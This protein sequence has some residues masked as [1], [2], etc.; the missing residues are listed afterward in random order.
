M[1]YPYSTL[2]KRPQNIHQVLGSN[3][4]KKKE[5][6]SLKNNDSCSSFL[7]KKIG[8][9]VG[10]LILF[11]L[12]FLNP[13]ISPAQWTN[14]MDASFLIGQPDFNTAVPGVT[15][16][17]LSSANGIAIDLAHNKMYVL[18]SKNHRVLRF[19][20]PIIS[21]YPT[22]EIVIGQPYFNSNLLGCTQNLLS[23]SP[24]CIAVDPE[25]NLW[26]SDMFNNRVIRFP[27]IWKVNYNQPN[28]DIVIGQPDFYSNSDGT[29]LNQL[30]W[31]QMPQFDANGNLYIA[32][33][34]NNRVLRFNKDN[35]KTGA[36]ANVYYGD[37]GS[38]VTAATLWGVCGITF[39]GSSMY[40]SDRNHHRVLR[41]DH[42]DSKVSASSADCVFGQPNFT[43]AMASIS[44]TGLNNPGEITSDA[45][46]TLFVDDQVNKRI[47]VFNNA[48]SLSNGANA[49]VVI[50]QTDFVS[51]STGCSINKFEGTFGLG[52]DKTNDILFVADGDNY[53]VLIF[54]SKKQLYPPLQQAYN[55]EF[56][57]TTESSTTISWTNGNGSK[58]LVFVKEGS[59]NLSGVTDATTYL[60]NSDFSSKGSQAGTSG[61]YCVY[62]GEA[63]SVDLKGLKANT[64]YTV[65]VLEY[66][67]EAGSEKYL[68]TTAQNN[69]ATLTTLVPLL[70]E[71]QATDIQFVNL[72]LHAMGIS[73]TKGSGSKRVVF[74]KEGTGDLAEVSNHSL[75]TASSDFS[76]RGTPAGNS[77]YYC[78]YNGDG[79]AVQV[80]NLK[81]NTLYTVRVCEYNGTEGAEEYLTVTASGNPAEH[82]I[83]K[84]DQVITFDPL[85]QKTVGDADFMLQATGGSSGNPVV[86]TCKDPNL[87]CGGNNG[88]TIT[89]KKA[90]TYTIYANQAGNDDYN[91]AKQVAQVL[92]VNKP[93]QAINFSTLPIKTYGDGSMVL[94]ATGGASGKPVVFTS[95]DPSIAECTGPNGSILIIK[96]PGQCKITANQDGDDW[97]SAAVPVQQPFTVKKA[98]QTITFA[99][100]DDKMY[101]DAP[102]RVSAT[103]GASGNPVYF[104]SSD[105]SIATCTGTNGETVSIVGGGSCIIY[106]HQ[107]GNEYYEP[108]ESIGQSLTVYKASQSILFD[109][110]STRTCGTESFEISASGGPSG[111]PVKFTS[112]DPSIA[113]CSGANG[114]IITI[115]KAGDCTIYADQVGNK[116]YDDAPQVA[117]ELHIIK[118]DQQIVF[119]PIPVKIFGD[120]PFVLSA[121]G[122]ASLN[123]ISF[124]M[125]EQ[126]IAKCSGSTVTIKN[127][128]S[129]QITAKQNGNSCYNPATASQTLTVK[130]A[131]QVIQF[132]AVDGEHLVNQPF[133]VSATGGGSN[134]P[135]VFT[136][137][138]PT[139]AIC[140]GTNGSTI[141]FLKA[142][143]CTIYANQAGS[144][145][146]EDAAQARQYISSGKQPQTIIFNALSSKTYGDAPFVISAIGGA[147]GNPVVFTS[148]DPTVAKCETIA[149]IT[150][151]TILRVGECT[152][153]A[154]QEG[155][156]AYDPAKEVSRLL[157][158]KKPGQVISFNA[159]RPKTFGDAPFTLSATGGASGNPVVFTSSHPE[160]VSCTGP[161]GSVVTIL[162]AGVCTIYANQAGNENYSAA[163][164]VGQ[165]LTIYKAN[166]IITF[167]PI[168]AKAYG[169][170]D[171]S[172]SAIGGASGLPIV[173]SSSDPS[174]A[175]CNGSVVTIHKAGTVTIYANQDGNESYYPANRVGQTI[176]ISPFLA[177]G[178]LCMGEKANFG[179]YLEGSNTYQWQE[180]QG[181]GWID[182]AETEVYAGVKTNLLS[183]STSINIKSGWKYRCLVNGAPKG[184]EGSISY[185]INTHITELPFKM[186]NY[187]EKDKSGSI[188]FSVSAQAEGTLLAVWKKN[189]VVLKAGGN[190]NIVNTV[191]G[192]N[193]LSSTLS[194]SNI[195]ASD[196]ADYV[197]VMKG[198]CGEAESNPIRLSTYG[199]PSSAEICP[200]TDAH[201]QMSVDNAPKGMSYQ[202]EQFISSSN[203]WI[204]L[205]DG[206]K[207]AEVAG[208]QTAV[209]NVKMGT[210]ASKQFRCSLTDAEQG[211]NIQSNAAILSRIVLSKQPEL[212]DF[213]SVQ[214][215][216]AS[217]SIS[218]NGSK[219][220][221]TWMRENGEAF[222]D[223]AYLPGSNIL[224]SGSK[225]SK[226]DIQQVGNSLCGLKLL[227]A[228]GCEQGSFVS[229][230]GGIGPCSTSSKWVLCVNKDHQL[231]SEFAGTHYQWQYKTANSD[232]ANL[233]ED[234]TFSH[235]Q[236]SILMIKQT[237]MALN[238]YWLRDV[239]DGVAKEENQITVLP[240]VSI[241]QQAEALQS[242]VSGET[243]SFSIT[244]TGA[245]QWEWMKDGVL[246]QDGQQA[247]GSR[248]SGAHTHQ[249]VIAGL[250]E[251][252]QAVY[253]CRVS[254]ACDEL[255]SSDAAL[256]VHSKAVVDVQP[257]NAQVC[258]G[259]VATFSLKASGDGR[260][261]YLWK[262][263]K[264]GQ[265]LDLD[266]SSKFAGETTSVLSITTSSSLLGSQYKCVV[267][268]RFGSSASNA[269]SF[270]FK[271]ETE[272]ISQPAAAVRATGASVSF[273]GLATGEGD[274]RYQWT[275]A[276]QAIAGAQSSTYTIPSLTKTDAGEYV[277]M[278]TA[279]CGSTSSSAAL[280]QVGDAPSFV[281]QPVD[282]TACSGTE[283]QFSLL[284]TGDPVLRYQW[285]Q[286]VEGVWISIAEDGTFSGCSSNVL[287]IQTKE[288]MD[289][290]KFRCQLLSP[291]GSALSQEVSLRLNDLRLLVSPSSQSVREGQ[292]VSWTMEASGQSPIAYQWR[293]N[294]TEM[295]GETQSVYRITRV[296]K[297]DEGDYDCVL[298][299]ACGTK[300]SSLAKLR[301]GRLPLVLEQPSALNVCSGSPV[302]WKV[303]ADVNS[304]ETIP[305]SS[306]ETINYQWQVRSN[307]SEEFKDIL[308]DLV[309]SGALS[310]R[311]DFV[312][313]MDL[314]GKQFRC[315]VSNDFGT[316]QSDVSSLKIGL[317]ARILAQPLA[318]RICS[319]GS[320]DFSTNASGT[321]E[322]SYQWQVESQGQWT[323]LAAGGSGFS[324]SKMTIH[325]N[326]GMDGWKFRCL[327]ADGACTT[328]TEAAL[329]NVQHLLELKKAPVDVEKQLGESNTFEV[330]ISGSDLKF[331]WYKGSA[332]SPK[333]Q[334]ITGA[335]GSS[336]HLS[337]LKA[338]DEAYYSVLV[339]GACGTNLY[340]AELKMLLVPQIITQPQ[341]RKV[342][343]GDQVGF[344]VR[345]LEHHLPNT[346]RWQAS[347]DHG[348]SWKEVSEQLVETFGNYSVL[349]FRASEQMSDL[350]F[351]CL[352]SNA[353]GTSISEQAQMSI[354]ENVKITQAAENL[355][356]PLH[357]TAV[358]SIRASGENLSYQ[359][360]KGTAVLMDGA[361][362]SGARTARLSLSDLNAA[363]E[364]AYS[365]QVFGDCSSVM[366]NAATL[367]LG[368]MP[369]SITFNALPESLL[370]DAD[371]KLQASTTSGLPLSYQSDNP[372][373]AVVWGD[374]V[375]L[376][377]IGTAKITATQS[378]NELYLPASPVT[379]ALVVKAGLPSVETNFANLL[380][381]SA[382]Q[383][384]ARVTSDGGLV[385]TERGICWGT[386]P[387]LSL[388]DSKIQEGT[389]LGQFSKEITGLKS[390]TQYYVKAYALNSLGLAYGKELS[391]TT[392]AELPQ[393]QASHLLFSK[394]DLTS[395]DLS[396]TRGNGEQCIVFIKQTNEGSASPMDFEQYIA[397]P[398][399]AAG[400]SIGSTGWYCVYKGSGT[401]ISISGL[402]QGKTYTAMVCEW[403][404]KAGQE[405]YLRVKAEGN[406]ASMI[407]TKREPLVYTFFSPDEDGRN[408]VWQID[409]ADLLNHCEITVYSRSNQVVYSS[410]GYPFP[411]DGKQN[412]HRLPMG[413]YY[414]VVK[415]E[416]NIKG[417]LVLM[418]R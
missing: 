377:G 187:V 198:D 81:R 224:F 53:R 359:W 94:T 2:I 30:S 394:V 405:R 139:V 119:D 292:S 164:Q 102:F 215:K 357:E 366:S 303:K 314:N 320:L 278:A 271:K 274:I 311:L 153:S 87:V 21:N 114:Q 287:R 200:G 276:G 146:Y 407:T 403:N 361:R 310:N 242:K 43:Q 355:Q 307:A 329:L 365:C 148:S 191:S 248:V 39:I 157:S 293:K 418:G 69:P 288:T 322:L 165:A 265:L 113:A 305:L 98:K 127:V 97:Y 284:A 104:T 351:R 128:G 207:D 398:E 378:G 28:A 60:A 13:K 356:K 343:L 196:A 4:T 17:T 50:G 129:T 220:R 160:I 46:G 66:T 120:A 64:S 374:K 59:G 144:D 413:E 316:V 55:I 241:S 136:S 221:Y 283:A 40:L 338:D 404:G 133:T 325:A 255:L 8:K 279:A 277:L 73:W 93:G 225:T 262:Q 399:F 395:F 92:V 286:Q 371:L 259:A 228:L 379:Q 364:G 126:V 5:V 412:G 218:T 112:S 44:R 210:A 372:Q 408:D 12:L 245:T 140:S 134:N 326:D 193:Q 321:N 138:D 239:V 154:N 401:S 70:P 194:I 233:P 159:L 143:S 91:A 270:S 67:G 383:V 1:I 298:S 201:L 175:S 230:V 37:G 155:N 347:T 247:S 352:V 151:V 24:A 110:L 382:A 15:G 397:S 269:V 35:I 244:Q 315:I 272:W 334:I 387:N 363:D 275:K 264:D 84:I 117:Q 167:D 349:S 360:Y 354:Q 330:E 385:V 300:N 182:L 358:F 181:A 376:V 23:E 105:A 135:V 232:W 341:S 90:G 335:T 209:L 229:E 386:Q 217:F 48:N 393:V 82:T 362:I 107:D 309:Y 145:K 260:L 246:L 327:V 294:G 101:G 370:S 77:G 72:S 236:T 158:I 31:P 170:E 216:T 290:R 252:D 122:G 319:G 18:D 324:S 253:R 185:K 188:S 280:L 22:A 156:E 47:L 208:S 166:Q 86:F 417:I 183:I 174:I 238:G 65:R 76:Y 96:K 20:Y 109:A 231:S 9:Q 62:N 172:V 295:A 192:A 333:E 350:S 141:T 281:Q 222:T 111:N 206:D 266:P 51:R 282:G 149:G 312:G 306:A 285:E 78:V 63:S 54:S 368:R 56:K 291:Y 414:F 336:L 108:A 83:D 345:A 214:G 410:I 178:K 328:A 415:G 79:N 348:L 147:S 289:Q 169:D 261:A 205:K 388:A 6:L 123:P 211:V 400:S 179:L 340:G 7:I 308:N 14:G 38:D 125:S 80:N 199:Q 353:V 344:S 391:F 342:C 254:N 375:H 396:W 197:C 115:L 223:G 268:N 121:K 32:D 161:N 296:S 213:A 132:V 367:G 313:T 203:S 373:V 19:A 124:L 88:S 29:A 380:G 243:A 171:F 409:N 89:I 168:P 95:S 152:I 237:S 384:D 103:G 249:L 227:C 106:P 49:D 332:S 256:E 74:M 304:S 52:Y 118:G 219:L 58:R 235:T 42:I 130:K 416:Y 36:T 34:N 27:E 142:G 299:N 250:T 10:V 16:N 202:W 240:S 339:I 85:P 234:G 61:Y 273:S 45:N 226:M 71:V 411:W 390:N 189:G 392:P 251:A 33:T 150:T 402:E 162:K 100:L 317:P 263:F 184:Q 57:N 68:T 190:L 257:E 369:Q 195:T 131:P 163:A 99:P 323:A 186:V 116:A 26:V 297:S 173:F 176:V 337:Q 331:Q 406:P 11:G 302:Q 381:S 25:G 389:G 318:G 180:N 177:P 41:Y 204:V 301:V 3:S 267:S 75:Y 212:Y 258:L 137:S 346:Y